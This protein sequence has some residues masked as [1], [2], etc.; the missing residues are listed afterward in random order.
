MAVTVPHASRN[1][2]AKCNVTYG[3]NWIEVQSQKTGNVVRLEV[4]P[5]SDLSWLSSEEQTFLNKL[6]VGSDQEDSE[7]DLTFGQMAMFKNCVEKY[8]ARQQKEQEVVEAEAEVSEDIDTCLKKQFALIRRLK[9]VSQDKSELYRIVYYIPTRVSAPTDNGGH[10]KFANLAARMRGAGLIQFDGS[11]YIGKENC[12]PKDVFSEMDEWNSREYVKATEFLPK[13]LR[14]L[15]KYRCEK[16]HPEEREK[17]RN[18]AFEQLRDHIVEIH[19]SLLESIDNAGKRMD[20]AAAE[21]EKQANGISSKEREKLHARRVGNVSTAL[22][23]AKKN[24]ANAVKAAEIF[25][26]TESLDPLFA[27]VREAI[28]ASNAALVALKRSQK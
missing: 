3:S 18:E 24:L 1:L 27:G 7:T 10:G 4:G 9:S 17:T 19:M 13:R 12:I 28:K 5:N 11:T 20:E 26:E 23:V 21:L 8:N 16:I 25:D 14:L 22:S 6:T 2:T 15:V